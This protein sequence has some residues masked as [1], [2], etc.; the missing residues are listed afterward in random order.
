[1]ASGSFEFTPDGYLQ[2]KI[3]W[4]STSNGSSANSSNVTAILYARRTNSYTTYGK[5]WSGWVHVNGSGVD[6]H[7]DSTVYVSSGWVEMARTT[8][9]VPHNNDGTKTVGIDGSVTGPTGTNLAGKTSRG[10]ANVQLDTIPRYTSITSFTVSKRNETSFTFNWQT[11]N[12]VDYV[13][14]STNNGSNWTGY[15]VTDGTSGSFVVS[16]LSPNTGYNC[17]IRVR[18]KDSQLNTDSS[19][20]YQTTY[21]VPTESFNSKT[22]NT[23]KM[24]WSCDS[25]VDHI[26][27]SLNNGNWVDAGNV[28]STQGTYIISGLSPNTTYS[29][30]TRV[31]RSA[32][33]TTYDTGAVSATT[34]DIGKIS[35]VSNFNHGDSTT[36][37]TTNPSGSSLVIAM[38]I[39]NTQI[40]SKSASTGSNTIS[41]NDS[42]LDSIYRLYGSDNTLTATF[43]LTTAGI[44]TNTKT[45]TITLKGNQKVAY[46]GSGGKKRAKVF[47]GIGGAVKRAVVWIGNNGRKRCI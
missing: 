8:Q 25:T 11:A 43:I 28:N 38:K 21:K 34:Y 9:T 35:S 46:V 20:V 23:I 4:S 26:W 40:L 15:D 39:G 44:Y 7:F 27:Y 30:K 5:S 45:A 6:V 29:I 41:F 32:V 33:Q 37:V 42:Q 19:T 17:K 10:E 31:R 24:N 12:T 1:M 22:L 14:Y 18:R 3:D 16:G 47:V 13:W 2:G 36:L